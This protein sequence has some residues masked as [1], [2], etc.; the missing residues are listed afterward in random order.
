MLRDV[1]SKETLH[2][3]RHSDWVRS[4]AF[5]PDGRQVLTGSDDNTA[6]LRD[7]ASKETLHTWRHD[8]N[9][10]SVAFSPDG[11]QVLTGSWDNTA[12]LRDA[13]SGKTLHTWRH[14]DNVWSVAF[15][16]DGRQ[17][18]TGAWD[19]TAVLRDVASGKTRHTWKHSSDV[20]TVAFSP[21]GRQVL[22][23][24]ADNTAV[25]RDV[26]S[27]ETLH[28]WRH[29]DNVWSVAFSP[30]GR[31]VLIGTMQ[32]RV[33]STKVWT[34]DY[35]ST[36]LRANPFPPQM[37]LTEAKQQLQQRVNTA[38]TLLQSQHQR[39]PP[40]F[41]ATQRALQTP[42]AVP[43][44]LTKGEFES[45]IKFN[46]RK[47]ATQATYDKKVRA[48]NKKVARLQYRRAAALCTL[49]ATAHC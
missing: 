8:D 43:P 1:A 37:A 36:V 24:S 41:V 9:V 38:M 30:D 14:D 33:S 35:G 32:L 29:D 22:T 26:A 49:E 15:S 11:R 16:P 19:K 6:V 25:L 40:Q 45:T 47:A 27:K 42:P 39:L 4:V 44:R 2:T 3:W 28:T 5:S 12:V 48:Y 21:D 17:V 7:V 23:G 31:Q 13:R 10:W 34:S 18:L 46:A 20:N